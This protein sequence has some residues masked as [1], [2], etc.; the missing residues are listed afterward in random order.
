M[1]RLSVARRIAG[2]AVASLAVLFIAAS[3]LWALAGTRWGRERLARQL[4]RMLAR[5]GIQA[6]LRA[7]LELPLHLVLE[8]V[9]VSAPDDEHELPTFEAARVVVR[10]RMAALLC[11]RLE[12]SS[13]EYEAPTLR[14]THSP[15]TL[16][17]AHDA[18]TRARDV[19]TGRW[20]VRRLGVTNGRVEVVWGSVRVVAGGIHVTA[21][22]RSVGGTLRIRIAEGRL[23][24]PASNGG[25][26]RDALCALDASVR[27]DSTEVQIDRFEA[28][29]VADV[30][31]GRI[32]CALPDVRDGG[33]ALKAERAS[34]E[35]D[36]RGHPSVIRGHVSAR[37]PL[38]L[39]NR[40]GR[41]ASI[42]GWASVDADVRYA[43]GRRLPEGRGTAQAH[44]VS[45]DDYRVARAIDA[46]L[47]LEDDVLRIPSADVDT[48]S[49][50]L[51]LADVELHPLASGAPL[52]ARVDGSRLRFEEFLRAIKVARHPHVSWAIETMRWEEIEG[53]I[54]PLAISGRFSAQTG[55]FAVFDGACD[56]EHCARIWSFARSTIGAR[57]TL[58][59]RAFELDDVRATLTG[60]EAH[61]SRVVIGF[62]DELRVEGGRAALS[63]GRDSPLASLAIAGQLQGEARVFGRLGDPVV[64]F[65][66]TVDGF[67]LDGDPLGDITSVHGRY[68]DSVLSFDGVRA[69]KGTSLYEVP[70][71]RI[72][73]GH[74][75][76][77]NVEAIAIAR[78]LLVRDLL[79]LARLDQRGPLAMLGGSLSDT[80]ARIR[81]VRHGPEDPL[82]HGT[83]FV[84]AD[85]GLIAPSAY[86]QHFDEGS[87]GVDVRWWDPAAGLAGV[88]V[89]LRTLALRDRRTGRAAQPEGSILASGQLAGGTIQAEAV[90]SAVPLARLGT[91]ADT[92][93][94]EGRVS[95]VVHAAGTIAA[96]GASADVEVTPLLV[97]KVPFGPSAFHVEAALGALVPTRVAASGT[98][99]GGE[100]TVR[101]LVADA[102]GLRG[103][104]TLRSLRLDPLVQPASTGRPSGA[105]VPEGVRAVVSGELTFDALDPRDIAH[106]RARFVPT[107]ASASLGE[108]SAR[109]SPDG[110]AVVLADDT[111]VFPPLH[112]VVTFPELR[113]VKAPT[114]PR[115]T[116]RSPAPSGEPRDERLVRATIRGSVTSLSR[117]PQMDFEVAVPHADLSL[118]VGVVP[119][120][121][122]ADGSF[123]GVVTAK[124][125]LSGLALGGEVRAH[126]DLVD[127]SWI[128]SELHQVDIDVG[129]DRRELRVI[130][131]SAT[132][133]DGFVEASGGS[134]ITGL[135][136]G[137]TTLT[138]RARGVHLAVARGVDTAFDADA[139]VVIDFRRLLRGG[140]HAV[141]VTG[142]AALD[143]LA[144]R[145]PLDTSGSRQ[146]DPGS[147]YDPSRDVVD[148]ALRLRARGPVQVE[149]DVASVRFVPAGDIWLRGT[150][151]RPSLDGRLISVRGGKL[152][153]RGISL[154]VARATLDFDDPAGVSPRIDLVATTDYRRVSAFEAPMA[155]ASSSGARGAQAWRIWLRA[156]GG[157]GDLHV[158]LTSDPPLSQPDI[159]L[160]LALGMTRPELDAM[161]A[162]VQLQA[163]A[164]L[165]VL[166]GLGG[167]ERIVRDVVPIDE[168]RFG[169]TYS[170]QSLVVVP[171]VTLGKRIGERMAATV[172]SSLAYQRIVGGTVSWGLGSNLWFEGLWENVAPVP[173]YPVGDFGVAVRWRLEL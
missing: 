170:P 38:A 98:L 3:S 114:G 117:G 59:S 94:I 69:R 22:A 159:V 151:Q 16:A 40:T 152:H 25:A 124:G 46:R 107:A 62:H 122:R 127:V 13:V 123:A 163:S 93:S 129:I 70:S 150:N 132:L 112:T 58:T 11:G 153:V 54:R 65:G 37:A 142:D 85:A 5:D 136:P 35:L 111:I 149:D 131:A 19:L 21:H 64:D 47:S 128:P 158:E 14:V 121:T 133:G 160:L 29:G 91:T 18:W 162:T 135:L 115:P 92:A 126:A 56:V 113:V 141:V 28:R 49:G 125:P 26:Y 168:V 105:P 43:A 166:A 108:Q 78:E 15:T 12:A 24:E 82:G 41:V 169:A 77:L 76:H 75:G 100:V 31:Q 72:G 137:L 73:F 146:S 23:D 74:D 172:T 104:A 1:G 120:L 145:R 33:V 44:D 157:Q 53:T 36:S 134:L 101:E 156:L 80:R 173:V 161:Q 8:D 9:R 6:T 88:D 63:L 84:T 57:A 27:V 60:G 167:A 140:S 148:F 52:R 48:T 17:P 95:G 79:S 118:L 87:I 96:L 4:E 130:R 45:V 97:G 154:D 55:S 83:I 99:L 138:L 109:L 119:D 50:T 116:G 2:V 67:V 34:I 42:Q 144:Y 30:D 110:A 71:L 66:G 171:D 155:F 139:R 51:R 81:Y 143:A 164:G 7:R 89:D 68:H 147:D 86:G 10:P 103:R 39:L 90:V 32:A 20:K 165:Q 102:R 106:A 61:A